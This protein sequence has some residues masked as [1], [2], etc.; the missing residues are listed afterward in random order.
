MI[1]RETS[2]V[3]SPCFSPKQGDE[4]GIKEYLERWQKQTGVK[5]EGSFDDNGRFIVK[6][7]KK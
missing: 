6:Q 4:K 5:W 2:I 3:Y 7:E 1:E